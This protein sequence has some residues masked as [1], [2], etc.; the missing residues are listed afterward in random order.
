MIWNKGVLCTVLST[1]VKNSGHSGGNGMV[2]TTLPTTT[3]KKGE[4]N[5]FGEKVGEFWCH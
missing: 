1:G 4:K 5:S 2:F 3:Q